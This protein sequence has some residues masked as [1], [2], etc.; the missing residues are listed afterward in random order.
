MAKVFCCYCKRVQW[1]MRLM[2]IEAVYPK[3]R[4][5][6]PA[7]GHKIYP[8]LLRGLAITR[9]D[10]VWA[11]DITYIPLKHLFSRATIHVEFPDTRKYSPKG[12]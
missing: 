5:T 4:T 8:Y 9:P 11:T 6:C 12:W 1:L 7:A 3:R 2:G 10:Q